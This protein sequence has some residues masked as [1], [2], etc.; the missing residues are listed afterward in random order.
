MANGEDKSKIDHLEEAKKTLYSR[1]LPQRKSREGILR[2]MSYGVARDWSKQAFQATKKTVK[3]PPSLMKKFFFFSVAFFCIALAFTFFKFYRGT[4]TISTENIEINVLGNAFVAGGEELPLQI[5]ITNNNNLPLELSDLLIEYPKGSGGEAA[6]DFVRIRKSLGEIRAGETVNDNEKVTLFGEQGVTK[7]IKISLE[8]RVQSSNAIF[9]KEMHHSVNISSAPISLTVDAPPSATSGQ[10]INLN[11]E[12]LSNASRVAQG[13]L[14]RVEYPPGFQFTSSIPKPYAGDNA[15]DLGDLATG[16]E[17]TI[18]VK[19]LI[20]GQDEE[21]KSFRTYVGEQ[22]LHDQ[23]NIAVI[24]NSYLQTLSITRPFIEA[25]LL[26]NGLDQNEFSVASQSNTRAQINWANNLP[27]KVTDVEIKA[28]ITGSALNNSSVNALNGFYDSGSD[29]IIWS[30]NTAGELASVEPGDRGTVDFSFSSASLFSEAGPA[31]VSPSITIEV[32]ISAK[33]PSEGNVLATINNFETK[34]VKI[35][36]DLQIVSK[37]LYYDGPFQNSGPIPPKAENKTTY[38]ILWTVTNSANTISGVEARAILPFYVRFTGMTSPPSE[39]LFYN[40][41]TREVLW[42]LEKVSPGAG[43]TGDPREVAFQ[44]ELSPS[45]SQVGSIPQL[46]SET[47]LTG[48][49]NF[50]N[51]TIKT[52]R[53]ALNTKLAND[54]QFKSGNEKVVE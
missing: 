33:Q 41:S 28:L 37:A 38:T 44:V 9:V 1:T 22:D 48:T 49:D 8:Y 26:V 32:S 54:S 43:L 5:Q 51:S 30:K 24:Y 52:T 12:V 23:T 18:A 15:W 19:G 27:T 16:V 4:N 40:E 29:T 10:E 6:G 25:H 13:M 36:S 3:I 42:K 17:K 46:L 2:Q 34:I 50:T 7:D 45:L 11:I 21:E 39:N 31:G 20:F 47:V 14:L 53:S 35:N